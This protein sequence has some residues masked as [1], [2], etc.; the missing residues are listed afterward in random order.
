MAEVVVQE[1]MK[2]FP[3]CASFYAPLST[4]TGTSRGEDE[5]EGGGGDF[6]LFL[7]FCFAAAPTAKPCSQAGRSGTRAKAGVT[8]SPVACINRAVASSAGRGKTTRGRAHECRIIE[9]D[10]PLFLLSR[11]RHRVLA[12]LSRKKGEGRGGGTGE[13]RER[14]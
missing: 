2:T 5:R 4:T 8:P 1:R 13:G 12:E 3:F 6:L 14:N 10:T 11:A 9:S 7:S